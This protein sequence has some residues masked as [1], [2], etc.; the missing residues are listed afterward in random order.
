MSTETKSLT[1][2]EG[3]ARIAKLLNTN[4]L[5][6]IGNKALN[7]FEKAFMISTAIQALKDALTPEYMKPIMALQGNKLGFKTD[8]DD[9][10]GYEMNVV[11]NCLIEAVLMGLQPH[12]NQFN[13]IAGNTYATKEGCGYLLSQIPGLKWEIV[14][15]LPRIN[16]DKTSAAVSAK[17]KY[18]FNAPEE[19]TELDIP[20]KMNAFMGADAVLGKATRKARK[21][22]YD[23][24]TGNELPEGDAQDVSAEVISSKIERKEGKETNVANTMSNIAKEAKA[25]LGDD[26]S[27][28]PP[29]DVN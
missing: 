20:I 25:N 12:G 18:T 10:G 19:I 23:K 13:I 6:V 3:Q 28:V 24:I 16:A 17:I 11:K 21:W 4:V 15:G 1:L 26:P 5:S 27:R 9:K 8:K 2:P 29:E 14:L 22:L 7:G